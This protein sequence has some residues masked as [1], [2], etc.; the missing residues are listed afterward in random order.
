MKTYGG[1]LDEFNAMFIPVSGNSFVFAGMTSS[2]GSGN[3][4]A[5]LVKVDQ[6]GNEQWYRTF[7]GA[8]DDWVTVVRQTIDGGFILSGYTKSFGA[9]GFDVYLI[10]TDAN[11]IAGFERII[12]TEN[13]CFIYPNPCTDI[14]NI[15]IHSFYDNDGRFNLFNINGQLAKSEIIH[16]N[17]TGNFTLNVSNLPKGVYILN[18]QSKTKQYNQ[19]VI[20]H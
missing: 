16:N 11:G 10:K 15:Q 13:Q 20:I 14:L 4:D 5:Y 2:F 17:G 12:K 3:M 1:V 19:K 8:N 7:G 6:N 9:G 18:I